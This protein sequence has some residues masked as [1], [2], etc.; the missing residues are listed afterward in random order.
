M[1]A[2]AVRTIYVKVTGQDKIESVTTQITSL[3]AKRHDVDATKPDFSIQTQQDIICHTAGDHCGLSQPAGLGGRRLAAGGRDWHY[4]YQC[5][6]RSLNAL[7]EIGLRMAL[8]RTP[9]RCA[10]S[11]PARGHHPEPGRRI[12][13]RF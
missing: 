6:F 4:E 7:G 13:W 11:I 8:G 3:L 5:W 1:G 10:D 12:G 9:G 2:D